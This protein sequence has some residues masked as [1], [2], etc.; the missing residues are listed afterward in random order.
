M[1]KYTNLFSKNDGDIGRTNLVRH[2][3]DT[4]DTAP[5]RQRPRHVPF[6]R[7]QEVEE[8]IQEMKKN[9]VIEPSSSPWCSPVVLVKKKMDRLGSV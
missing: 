2:K 1:L 6:A 8:M 7:E 5:I 9:G 3:I 4:G